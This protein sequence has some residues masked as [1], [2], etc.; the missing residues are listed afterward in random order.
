MHL[1]VLSPRKVKDGLSR[2]ELLLRLLRPLD[3]WSAQ[4]AVTAEDAVGHET[5]LGMALS[6][7]LAESSGAE[8]RGWVAVCVTLVQHGATLASLGNWGANW[9][10]RPGA[11]A[12]GQGWGPRNLG[13]GR[14]SPH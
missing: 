11:T 9:R 13:G 3:A 1:C 10:P 4:I 6:S 12:V 8:G 5:P 2:D 14:Q 7:G